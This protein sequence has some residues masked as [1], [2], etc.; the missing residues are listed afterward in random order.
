M[1]RSLSRCVQTRQ[2]LGRLDPRVSSL[3]DRFSRL[4]VL[5]FDAAKEDKIRVRCDGRNS[6]EF[7]NKTYSS[8]SKVNL[9][10]I[11]VVV[12]VFRRDRVNFWVPGAIALSLVMKI[13]RSEEDRG[14][15]VQNQNNFKKIVLYFL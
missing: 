2:R 14:V 11:G 15:A 12:N 1:K 7:R 13:M 9:F 6:E 8:H 5:F 3:V 4:V 10:S